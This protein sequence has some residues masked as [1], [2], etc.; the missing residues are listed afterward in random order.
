M[1]NWIDISHGMELNPDLE[2]NLRQNENGILFLGHLIL[3]KVATN[4]LT[5]DD[6]NQ[7]ELIIQN[8][9][10]YDSNGKKING[11]YDRGSEES[12]ASSEHFVPAANRRSISHDNLTAISRLA[13]LFKLR[14]AKDIA[15]YGL[16]HCMRYDNC[17]PDKPRWERIQHPRDYFFW[18]WEGGYKLLAL[19]WYPIFF[20]SNLIS[21]F[22]PQQETSGKL[23]MFNRLFLQKTWL[24][25][26]NWAICNYVLKKKYGENWLEQ[27]TA[28]YFYQRSDN[29]IRILAKEVKL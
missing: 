9:E 8:L 10:A 23:L 25:R 27:V 15:A 13:S 16:N 4:T 11:L 21:C 24:L 6:I 17:Y 22:T 26:F 18:L 12:L 29:P 7:V 28:I 14:Y 20:F 1:D 5:I 2:P 3:L 19:P